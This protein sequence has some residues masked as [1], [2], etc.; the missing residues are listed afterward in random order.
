MFAWGGTLH[1]KLGQRAGRPGIIATLEKKIVVSVD[2]GDFHSAAL[3]NKGELYTW[4]GGGAHFN[5][6]QLGHGSLNDIENPE[7]VKFFEG[8]EVQTISCGGFHTIALT[9]TGAFGWGSGTYGELGI[10]E[11]I[12]ISK[13]RAIQIKLKGADAVE[14]ADPADTRIVKVKCG[15]HHSLFLS[16][17][18][19]IPNVSHWVIVFMWIWK[20]WTT[21]S[22]N[23]I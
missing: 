4:G 13:P 18:S 11:F 19:F 16:G 8:D 12:D 5:K 14:F 10:G 7:L 23:S 2:C 15:G 1:K 22:Q 6:G 9:N 20:S 3:T 21:W 17:S